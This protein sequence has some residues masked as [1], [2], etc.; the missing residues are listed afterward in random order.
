MSNLIAAAALKALKDWIDA[1]EKS[2]RAEMTE[3]LVAGYEAHGNKS[4]DVRLED[5]VVA[6]VTLKKPTA[7]FKIDDAV[8]FREW[9]SDTHPL[10]I[11]TPE[12]YVDSAFSTPFLK[13][14]IAAEDGTAIDP[15]TGE[16]VYGVTYHPAGRPNSYAVT[17]TPTGKDAIADAWRAGKLHALFPSVAPALREAGDVD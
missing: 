6:S 17:F 3:E 1:A 2:L 7:G 8:L 10:A 16:E 13:T 15:D 12:P 5:D 14:L 4:F 9:C 11:V